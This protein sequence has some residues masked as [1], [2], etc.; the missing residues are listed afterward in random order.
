M[1]FIFRSKSNN[2]RTVT[3]TDSLVVVFYKRR[4]IWSILCL[5]TSSFFAWNYFGLFFVISLAF[6]FSIFERAL[7]L[8]FFKFALHIFPTVLAIVLSATFW[9]YSVDIFKAIFAHIVSTLNMLLP[10]IAMYF[11]KKSTMFFHHFYPF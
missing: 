5:F 1:S 10:I 8:N 9:L 4:F 11:L 3:F 6:F 2:Y 7:Q